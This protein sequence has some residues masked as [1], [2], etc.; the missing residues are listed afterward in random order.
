MTQRVMEAINS[1]PAG[2]YAQPEEVAKLALYLASD[3]SSFVHG[4]SHAH[5]WRM[6][7]QVVSGRDH[8]AT[9]AI[10]G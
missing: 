4:C 3:D 10:H 6:D 8:P 7:R 9:L 5:R 1:V 2:R